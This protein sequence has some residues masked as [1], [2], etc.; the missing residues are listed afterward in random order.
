MQFV[1]DVY[2]GHSATSSSL[3]FYDFSNAA[4]LF[5]ILLGLLAIYLFG[6]WFNRRFQ[7][8]VYCIDFETYQPPANLVLS[9]ESILQKFADTPSITPE[10]IQ[11][12]RN[13]SLKSGVGECTA[14]PEILATSTNG[15]PAQQTI[16]SARIEAE[17]ILFEVVEKLL[18][19]TG[20]RGEDISI[21]VVN[22]SLFCPTPS[23]AAMLVHRFNMRSDVLSYNLGGMGCSAGVISVDLAA[24]LL[25]SSPDSVALVCSY[26]NMTSSAYVGN[27]KDFM[28]QNMLFRL[29]GAALV[30]SNRASDRDR[31]KLQLVHSA[32]TIIVGEE[33]LTSVV[34]MED[35]AGFRGVRLSKSIMRVATVALQKNISSFARLFLPWGEQIKYGLNMVARALLGRK[36]PSSIPR[37]LSMLL[38]F[39]AD[40]CLKRT[41]IGSA[42]CRR[43]CKL[44]SSVLDPASEPYVPSFERCFDHFCVHAGGRAVLD[45]IEAALR[46]SVDKMEASRYVLHRYG[47]TSSA[48]IWYEMERHFQHSGVAKGELIWQIAFGSGFKCNSAVWRS[49][50]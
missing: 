1:F 5:I 12:M 20:L 32:R 39:I 41:W 8:P 31:S 43:V 42:W 27:Q 9:T 40:L 28:L 36:L 35:D 50:K 2:S 16:A 6:S 22:S 15:F 38:Y 25:K 23:L 10:S 18:L 24:R 49:L 13:I 3:K 30:M 17:M 19:K 46:L 45:A 37:P 26:E 29:G 7:T 48:S 44:P 47:N 33:S 34:Q 11:F 21:L 14:V 4:I